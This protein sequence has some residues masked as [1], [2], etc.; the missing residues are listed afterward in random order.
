[1]GGVADGVVEGEWLFLFHLFWL[2]VSIG[3]MVFD[4][5]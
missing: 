3:I 2:L 1:M 4:F 5:G